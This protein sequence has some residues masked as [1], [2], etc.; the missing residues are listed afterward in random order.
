MSEK[1]KR[2]EELK[3]LVKNFNKRLKFE[4]RSKIWFH[5]TY[6]LE[7]IKYNYFIRKVN[8]VSELSEDETIINAI[9][10]YLGEQ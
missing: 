10:K 9:K 1:K 2:L 8:I 4:R 5:E 3:K 7:D 6:L